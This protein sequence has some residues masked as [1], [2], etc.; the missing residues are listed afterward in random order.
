MSLAIGIDIGGTKVAGGLVDERGTVIAR[1]RRDTPH[2][3][4]KAAVVEDLR[5]QPLPPPHPELLKYFQPPRAVLK[6]ARPTIEAARA[7]FGVKEGACAHAG[8]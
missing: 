5:R 1:A 8:G 6:R 7:A 2:R 4:T 3:S